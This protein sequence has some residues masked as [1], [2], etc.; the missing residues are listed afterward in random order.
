MRKKM[1]LFLSL[2]IL[3]LLGSILIRKGD[4]KIQLQLDEDSGISLLLTTGSKQETICP[5]FNDGDGRYYF[6]LPSFSN[7]KKIHIK[8]AHDKIEYLDG[9]R[10][11]SGRYFTYEEENIYHLKVTDKNAEVIQE[12]DIVMLKSENLPA[13]FIKT[14][15]GNMAYIHQDK[16]N[17]EAGKIDIIK[18]NGMVDYAGGLERISGRGNSTW[19]YEKKPYAIKLMEAKPLLG[20]DQGEK[21]CLLAGWREGAKLNSKIAFDM[22]EEIG[23]AYS[24]QCTW[25]DLYLNGEY[26][27][28]YLL[29][30]SISVG[31]GGVEISNLEKE[32]KAN[33]SDIDNADVFE[34]N[35]MKGYIINNGKNITGGYL[36]EKDTTSYWNNVSAGFTTDSED[37][38]SIKSPKHASKEQVTYIYNYIQKINDLISSGDTEYRN[39]IDSDSFSKK[40]I[41]DE[42]ALSHDVNV[43][44]MYYYKEKND[45][46]LYA[47]PVWDFDGAFGEGNSGWG[48]GHWV[49]YEESLIN[50]FFGETLD[51]YSKLY[52]DEDFKAQV[53]ETY[54]EFLPYLE[55][56]LEVKIDQ[57]A[58][59][60]RK[61][62]QLDKF[63]WQYIDISDDKP[64]H[65]VEFDNNVRYLKYF[66]ANR[67]NYLNQRWDVPYKEF[68]V[69]V[70][71]DLHEVM[72]M[73]DGEIIEIREIM[74]GQTIETLPY[75]DEEIYWGWYFSYSNEKFRSQLPIYEDVVFYARN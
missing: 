11:E 48:E 73:Q 28:I 32:N 36:I 39:Y 31:E 61:S 2:A 50:P 57:Y 64:G 60:I 27:G 68:S 33:N 35:G 8:G 17:E 38:F 45:D 14:D 9:N 59:W 52:A 10:I 22:A 34:E 42:I 4:E 30:E 16:M 13:V 18:A 7:E 55:Y 25:I 75:L 49:N 62:V 72:F 5:W 23:L 15:S 3:L 67:L 63:R 21:W 65:Y 6:F 29:T 70:N 58:D 41:V 43:T 20:M 74:D 56:I 51:W 37:K 71:E 24:P 12:Y 19:E 54:E 53:I 66:L 46:L 69:P 47:G 26:A 40:F 1:W 44:S